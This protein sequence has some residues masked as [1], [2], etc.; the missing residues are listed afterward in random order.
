MNKPLFSIVT[1]CYNAADLLEGTIKS[2]AAQQCKNFEYIII[3]GGSKD[4]TTN[5]L[6]EYAHVINIVISEGDNGIYDAMN[7]SLKIASGEFIW[8]LNAGDQIYEPDTLSILE[9]L[10]DAEVDVL[11]GEVMIVDEQ[12]KELGIRSELTVHQLP[13]QLKRA[14]MK[15]GMIVCHQGFIPRTI[16]AST[17]IEN[18][19]SADIDWVIRILEKK[20]TVLNTGM[21]LAEYLAGGISKQKWYRSLADRWN[22]LR[23]H[24]GLLSALTNHIFILGRAIIHRIS[25]GRKPSY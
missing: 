7:K 14:D 5:V 12:R 4:H 6:D 23:T 8:F 13:L 19:L 16:L 15:R 2:V 9:E 22:I 17:F 20:P 21:I 3:D 10:A 11:Y 24:F 18:N 25:R 1:V